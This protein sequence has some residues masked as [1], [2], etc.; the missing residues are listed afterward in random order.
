MIS[1]LTL[2]AALNLL[3]VCVADIGFIQLL[4]LIIASELYVSYNQ[5]NSAI[6][7]LCIATILCIYVYL[8][9]FKYVIGNSAHYTVQMRSL[10]STVANKNKDEY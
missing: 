1:A 10:Y 6:S 7:N 3:H 2:G 4:R 9:H 8:K 5:K